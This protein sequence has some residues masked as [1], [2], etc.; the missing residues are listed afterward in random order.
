MFNKR[1][2]LFLTLFVLLGLLAACQPETVEVTRVVQEEVTRVITETVV[3]EG[4]TV[5]VTRIVTEEVEVAPEPEET[6]EG[7]VV[8][9]N[10]YDTSDI[11]TLD[12]Q[13][14][15]DVTSINYIEN[16]FVHLTN[17]DL[18]TTEIVPEAAT[19]W[20]VSE[21]G[22][23]YTFNI[24]TDIPWVYHNPVTGETTQVDRP[25]V[26]EE[27]EVTGE[28]PAFV[29]AQ[30][31]V[32]GIKRA[33]DPNIGSYYSGVVAPLIS[34]CADVLDYEDPADIPQELVDA[35]GVSAPDESTLVI[36]LEFPAS[37]F[38]SMTPMWT[39]TAT[40]DWVI[41]EHGENW[42]EAGNIVTNGRYVLNEW[43]HGVRRIIVRN[44]LMPEDM[45]GDGN[46]ERFV[47]NVV[48]DTSTGYA[49]WLNNEVDTA[50]I[51]DAE[52]QAHLEEFADETIQIPDLAVFYISFNH[53]K[54]PFDQVE[55]RRAFSAA[56]DRETFVREVRQGQGLPM[57]HFA[58]PGIFGAPPIDEVGVG[59]DPEF[60]REQLSE[61]GYPD[62]E[63]LPQVTL[64]GYSGQATLNWI[65]YAQN[66]W[67]E[68][69]GCSADLIQIEQQP[70]AE[71]LAATAAS[72]PV[73]E[74]PHMWTLGW[75]PD[76]ADENNWVGDV[77]WC[78]NA[79]NRMRRECTE[80]DDLIVEAREETDPDRRIELYREIEERFFGPEGETP[81][82]PLYLRIA[83]VAEH[84]WL[85]R[86]PALFGGEQY[87][88]WSIDWEAKQAA[89][90]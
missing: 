71:L 32:N 73:A 60:A 57:R 30:D 65:E 78:G 61:A 6:A 86:I 72:V 24:R 74:S 47:V 63:G 3:E 8:T 29:T 31:F 62:C 83:F 42:I 58:P 39:L 18:E 10:G 21:D 15:E 14:G 49:L 11:P 22:L 69:L 41:A 54:A 68:N 2:G 87:Y 46:I 20:E 90:Q 82:A 51:P 40:P 52:L 48:P 17:Y 44:P 77:I 89:Q 53:A 27:G 5:E 36:E 80:T 12:P 4:E 84:T 64:L 66:Q 19:D 37:Y 45:Q 55:V 38:L 88:N 16:L 7:D 50:G 67:E 9:F 28:E 59:Y 34:G 79:D 25:V 81:F 13:I 70:F 1:V 23:T 26:D 76:Y 56:F 43:V 85:D 35:I 75:G 33:C